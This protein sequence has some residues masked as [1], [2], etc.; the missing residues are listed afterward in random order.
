MKRIWKLQYEF[1]DTR[2]NWF[3]WKYYSSWSIRSYAF[4][5]WYCKKQH[6][7]C[8]LPFGFINVIVFGY[9]LKRRTTWNNLKRPTTSKK[10][11]EE[12]P[13]TTYNKQEMTW[14]ELH[15]ARND[16]KRPTA[17]KKRPETTYNKQETT[18]NDPQ[19]V[20]YYLKRPTTSKKFSVI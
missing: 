13:E 15:R 18:W 10:R 16:L 3:T 12:R 20:R 11:P 2:M 19:R 9:L 6:T 7:Y 17:S 1:A 8:F 5:I 4:K 14:N